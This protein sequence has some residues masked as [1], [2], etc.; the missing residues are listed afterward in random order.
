MVLDWEKD[1]VYKDIVKDL[2]AHPQVQEMA[3]YTQ[4]H[5]SDRLTHCITVSYVSYKLALRFGLN[6]TAVA[7][8]GILHDLFFY[9]WRETKFE[10][11]SH[12][13]IHPRVAL[14]NAEKITHLSPMEKDIILKHMWGATSELPHYRESLLVDLVDDYLAVAEFFSPAS[15]RMK[16]LFHTN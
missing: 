1:K 4:H 12:A 7:R 11:G 16:R 9:D 2:L 6:A 14:R 13:F 10:L 15:A 8:A 5:H 3:N